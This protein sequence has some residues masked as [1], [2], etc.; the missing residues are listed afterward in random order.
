MDG[1]ELALLHQK[2]DR[3]TEMVEAQYKRQMQI[4]ELAQEVFPIA[5][6]AVKLAI[7]ELDE[8]GG[9][10][11]LEDL[12]Y[13]LKR[14]LRDTRML[15]KLLDRLEAVSQLGDEVEL[16][17]KQVFNN[18]VETLDRLE[19]E[20][21]FAFAQGGWRIVQKIVSE[22]TEDD[23]NALGDNI[24]TIL[25]TVRN[26]TQ[27]EIMAL[28]NNAIDAIRQ[29]DAGEENVSIWWLIR[30]MGDPKVRRGLARTLNIV[31]ALADQPDSSVKN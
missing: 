21:Y 24:V 22:F 16:L 17:G 29:D 4:E 14:L 6:H 19:R 30:E 7:D 13:L 1:N 11:Q 18:M 3:L 8:I 12:L 27:P 23:V 10:F 20:G 25:K 9:E 26:M 28:A 5:N 31:K 2:V 15:I